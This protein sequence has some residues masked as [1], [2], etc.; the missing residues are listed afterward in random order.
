MLNLSRKIGYLVVCEVI[1]TVY[2]YFHFFLYIS[3]FFGFFM[4]EK[5]IF[6]LSC[7]KPFHMDTLASQVFHFK[8]FQK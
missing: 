2:R 1:V 5:F 3:V 6:L 8:K 4:L 7:V